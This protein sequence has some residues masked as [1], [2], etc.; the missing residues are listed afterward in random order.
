MMDI[1]RNILN[2]DNSFYTFF[3]KIG[4]VFLLNILFLVTSLPIVTIGASS[5]AMYAVLNKMIEEKEFSLFKDYFRAFGKNFLSST[6]MWLLMLVIMAVMMIDF[7]YVFQEM[8][9]GFSY[10]MRI[11]TIFVAVMF[12][13][14]A[15][16]VFPLIVRFDVPLKEIIPA[17]VKIA[18]RHIG[19]SLESA[20]FTLVV[21]GGSAFIL[22]KGWFGGLFIL[23]PVISPG[24]H[25]FMQS[26]LYRHMF[27]HYIEEEEEDPDYVLEYHDDE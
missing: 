24:L 6:L 17:V 13:M 4:W 26:Y 18:F 7:R 27:R 12:C 3:K 5:A 20:A 11:G 23:F 22:S 19:L 16:A 1:L 8:T 21:L 14:A 25:A 2:L 9:G 15:N 10:V